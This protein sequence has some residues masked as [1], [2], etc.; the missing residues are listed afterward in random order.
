MGPAV[1]LSCAQPILERT[2]ARAAASDR[3]Y[4]V[5]RGR[6]FGAGAVA[7]PKRRSDG[8]PATPSEGIVNLQGEALS[9]SGFNAP[10]RQA[11]TLRMS[12]I[13]GW[14]GGRPPTT[15]IVAF[16]E[17]TPKGYV[18]EMDACRSWVHSG[19]D[20]GQLRRLLACHRN[21][22]CQQN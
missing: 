8:G 13:A 7:L 3:A 22:T 9:A 2:Y 19:D 15:P 20:M 11:I 12:C 6:V 21:G 5:V 1:A 18:L 17:R 10:F 16:L 14:C 4:L